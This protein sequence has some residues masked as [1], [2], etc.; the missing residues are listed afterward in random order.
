M[1][2]EE[3]VIALY[4]QET[5]TVLTENFQNF[6]L[7]LVDDGSTD[8]TV[9][10]CLPFIQQH[11]NIKLLIFSRNFGH[12]IASTAGLDHADGDLVVLMDSDLQ[13]PP[14]VIPELVA[15]MAEGYDV[16]CASRLNRNK[17]SWFK[18][19]ASLWFYRISRKMTGFE[20]NANT[21]NFRVLNR[22]VVDSIN[23]MKES[24]RHLLMMFAYVG[25]KTAT[26]PYDCPPRF[27]GKS[28][29]NIRKLISLSLDSIIGF[30]SRPL[31]LMSLLSVFISFVM[32]IYAGFILLEKLFSHQ[33]LA[34]GIASVIFLV[35][36]LFSLLFLFL[37]LISEYIS[38]I[39]VETKNR[40][41]YTIE[42]KISQDSFS[43][44]YEP[45]SI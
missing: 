5:L 41:L 44:R 20:L 32:M 31:R 42:R 9:A 37:A 34:D 39:L 14:S 2:N 10:V 27:A 16:V 12:E 21:G 35:A 25:F 15:K 22:K 26:V 43:S 33:H 38:R 29:Y 19:T 7:I 23:M 4:I 45:T 17:E 13:H 30:S 24:N 1:H 8:Q 18:K 6:E 11:K 28:K 40:P 3:A 36:G